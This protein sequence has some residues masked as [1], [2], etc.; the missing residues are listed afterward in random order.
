MIEVKIDKTAPVT[1]S[2]APEAWSKENVTVKLTAE[3]GES[4]VAKTFYSIN[5]SEYVEGTSFTVD[6]EGV[7]EVSYY[8]VDQ[9]GNIE[10]A[11]TTEVKIDK[12]APVTASDAPEA[13]SKENV[14]V[15]LTAEDGE[16]GVAKTFY[17]INGSEYVE[18]T[19]FTVDKEGIN[20][21]SYYSVDQAGNIEKAQMIE[22]KIDKTAPVTASD[23]PEAWSKEDVTVKLTATDTESGVAKTF[24]SINGSEYKEGTSFTVDKEGVN[25]ISF[26]SIDQVDNIE[27][28]QTIE[29]KIDKTAPILTMDLKDEYKLGSSLPLLYSANDDLSD[30]VSEEM[31]VSGPNETSGKVIANGTALTLDK[32]GIYNVTVKA[33]NGAGL[34]TTIQ[35]QFVVYIPAT[36]E[37][38]PKVI[39]GNNGVFT[40]RADLPEGYNSQGFDLN[41]AKLNGVNALTSNNGYYNQAKNGQFKFERSDFTWASSEVM[42]EFRCYLEGY[43]VVGQTTVKVQK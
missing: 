3:D 32:P 21:V 26:Y 42:V 13:W 22:V 11:Q 43:L 4:G 19:S 12:T 30:I 17:S 6:K 7:N 24:Y 39:K 40:V 28:V 18:G 23:A 10:K 15:K 2:D 8:S 16:S 36:I 33:T 29:V 37:V 35:K 14:T 41:T 9:A 1:A 5:G 34:I 25:E 20:E 38:T 31:I 27:K